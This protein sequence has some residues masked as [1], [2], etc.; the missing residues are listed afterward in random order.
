MVVYHYAKMQWHIQ[1]HTKHKYFIF[2]FILFWKVVKLYICVKIIY[3]FKLLLVVLLCNSF[4]VYV[5]CFF[6]F[7]WMH[8][9]DA[10]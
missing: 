8:M 2:I 6:T 4:H 5:C 7:V 10:V 9:M 1:G 3:V